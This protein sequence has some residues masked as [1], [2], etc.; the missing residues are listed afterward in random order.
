MKERRIQGKLL[1]IVNDVNGNNKLTD[2]QIEK[3]AHKCVLKPSQGRR[4]YRTIQ[5]AQSK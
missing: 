1:N 4:H 3:R 5:E 2:V